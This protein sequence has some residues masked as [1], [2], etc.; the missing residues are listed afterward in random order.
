[1]AACAALP[2]TR[3]APAVSAPALSE[4]LTHVLIFVRTLSTGDGLRATQRGRGRQVPLVPDIR[5]F[6][7]TLNY[8]F[9][10]LWDNSDIR[11]LRRWVVEARLDTP[12]PIWAGPRTTRPLRLAR[13]LRVRKSTR[14]NSSHV[15][16][17]YAVFC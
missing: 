8:Q 4:R 17:S 13:P 15:N 7:L 14:L 10:H 5:H 1:G 12:S 6:G 11:S 2:A 16:I 9:C 3:R